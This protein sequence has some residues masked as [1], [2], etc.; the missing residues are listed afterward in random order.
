MTRSALAPT[1]AARRP[2]AT[3]ISVAAL[4]LAAAAPLGRAHAQDAPVSLISDTE[5][6]EIIRQ[7]ADPI[8]RAAGL[9]PKSVR[10]FIVS[11][12]TREN[13]NS[14][15]SGGQNMFV[16][17]GL[18]FQTRSPNELIGVFA[19][20][21]GHMAGGHIVRSTMGERQ[22]LAT[23]LLTLGL[24]IAAAAAGAPD[25]AG[26]LLYS[27]SEFAYLT[28]AGFTRTQEASADQAAVTYLERSG[29]S[30]R[31][32]VSFFDNFRYEEVF[33][34]IKRYRYFDDHPLSDDRID[35][36]QTR[37]QQQPHWNTTDTP[38]AIERHKIL[39][40]KLKAYID[41]PQQTLLDYPSTDTSFP[42]RY[43]RAIAYSRDFEVDKASG[44]LDQLIAERP[45]DPYIYQV[46]GQMYFDVGRPTDAEGPLRKAVSLKPDAPELR[47]LLG[48]ALLAENDR[49]KLDEAIA[50]L[51]KGVA[52]DSDGPFSSYGWLY[53]AQAYDQK[54]EQGLARLA[55]AEENFTLGQANDARMF[56]MRARLLLP[57]GSPE[58]RRAT[59]IVLVSKPTNEDLRMLAREGSANAPPQ[60]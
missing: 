40:A 9:D 10:T 1:A 23:Y 35:A 25:A 53:L 30:A 17:A 20:E 29:Q 2:L 43:A 22:T 19:H 12:P 3:V 32:L 56:A 5:V 58:W 6:D 45:D 46:K 59:D 28:Q 18:I 47:I 8:F 57:R 38:E 27:A 11:D 14:F 16:T 24:G 31:G 39:I 13:M 41:L 49:T 33:S 44:L 60:R 15:V 55:A 36:L 52:L 48:Q 4:A 7:D 37:A 50:H 54:G 34:E 21:T 51:H 42:A 26:G